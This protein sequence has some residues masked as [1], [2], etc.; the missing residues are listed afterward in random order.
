MLLQYYQDF[1]TPRN[2]EECAAIIRQLHTPEKEYAAF[3]LYKGDVPV[4]GL[5]IH[6]NIAC[7]C[8]EPTLTWSKN[9][10]LEVTPGETVTFELENGEKDGIS[11]DACVPSE[12]AISAFL[13]FYRTGKLS[14]ILEWQ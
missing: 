12:Q 7:L 3:W 2:A 5:F 6:G 14:P 4:L 13:D 9:Q 1:F 10:A 11:L 8:H